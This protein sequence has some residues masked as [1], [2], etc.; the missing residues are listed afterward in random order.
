M[1]VVCCKSSITATLHLKGPY[2]CKAPSEL[3]AYCGGEW[4]MGDHLE[5][6]AG[7][8]DADDTGGAAHAR[9]VVG[10]DICAHL[11]VIHYHGRQR[12]RGGK[13]GADDDQDVNLHSL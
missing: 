10:Q 8:V 7:H 9:E 1:N 3:G 2:L 6:V 11:E 4:V 5:V 13:A 12:G